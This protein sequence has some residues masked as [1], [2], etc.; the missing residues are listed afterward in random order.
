MPSEKL[1]RRYAVAVFSLAKERN[2][3]D[4]VGDDLATIASVFADNPPLKEFFTAPIVARGAKERALLA[5]FEGKVH[6]IALHTLLLL[7]RKRRETLLS[8]L[9]GEYRKLRLAGRG[10]ESLTVASARTL[11]A[12]ELRALVGRFERLYGKKFEVTQ[13]VEPALIGGVRIL[14]G[15]RRI[16]GS[17]AGR[18]DALSRTLF[19]SN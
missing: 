10:E 2:A 5:A 18:L 19:A 4:A 9:L 1:A 11:S 7:V 17:V 15:D 3:V 12:D 13:V 16:D 8:G 6:E 14:M